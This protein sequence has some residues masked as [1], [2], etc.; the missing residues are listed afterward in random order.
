MYGY[1]G[2]ILNV[3]LSSGRIEIDEFHEGY[4][5]M[6]LGG[7]GF[8]ANYIYRKVDSETDPLSEDNYLLFTT[9]PLN[10]TKFW[11]TGRGH[12][13][14]ISPLTGLFADSNYGGDFA[15]KVKESG[16]DAVAITGKSEKSVYISINDG[17]AQIKPADHLWGKTT[18]ETIE[19]IKSAE[20]RGS[21]SAVIG[22][23]GENLIK[24]ASIICSGR[25]LSAAGRCGL[26][27]V[28]GSKNCKGISVK[29][30]WKNRVYGNHELDS[31]LKEQLPLLR[32]N[33]EI[34]RKYGTPFNVAKI[35]KYGK[36]SS[37]NNATEIFPGARKISGEV[38]KEKYITDNTA[39]NRCP[40]ACG[41][42]V[43]VPMGKYAGKIV[44]MPEYE[45][46][47]S[48]GSMLENS[49]ILSIINGNNACDSLGID[50][51]SMG[52]TLSFTAECIEKGLPVPCSGKRIVFGNDN[53]IADLVEKTAYR[54]GI[55]NFLAEGSEAMASE[56]GGDAFK[57]LYTVKGLEVA[58]HSARSIRHMGLSYAT[59]T[60][61]GS[62]HDARPKYYEPEREPDRGE[63]PVYCV[64]SQHFT[65]VGDSLVMCRFVMERGFG[66]ELNE[67]L[68]RL[69]NAVT[70][71]GLTPD[72]LAKTGERIYN[73]ER[74]INCGRGTDIKK[75][76]LPRRV[77]EEPV[78]EGPSAGM[79]CGNDTHEEMLREY[80]KL[81]GW[82]SN[83]IPTEEKV[84]EL[85]IERNM[86]QA[87]NK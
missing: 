42:K 87:C 65:A 41:K 16:F 70:G 5:R 23:A 13:A 72:E 50:T 44:K 7:N 33:T 32:E 56:I 53:D 63:I 9:G 6:F 66:T 48:L 4:A 67:P 46:L 43:N 29:G 54:K 38:L 62:H 74:L 30:G 78:P 55:G 59:S 36:L 49:D 52:V 8:A 14:A 57:Y 69:I 22:P 37:R 3:D 73:L 17:S 11:G 81:R 84:R 80:Y 71:F 21:E 61:G 18:E 10:C 83:G 25:R 45:T 77:T 20:G 47:Y 82:D 24:F 28:L 85:G 35:N 1:T 75:D 64:N 51:I 34:L 15:N 39:C 76:S 19:I 60:R 40:V 86:P 12:A 79:V 58:G 27:T 2:K 26:G 31:V 68:R